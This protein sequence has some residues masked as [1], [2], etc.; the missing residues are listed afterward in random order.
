[1]SMRMTRR[2]LLRYAGLASSTGILAACQ[3]KVVEVT[4]IVEKVVEK[5]V[6]K[7]VKETVIVEGTPKV[8]EKVVKETVVVA[9][10]EPVTL[11]LVVMNYSWD[12]AQKTFAPEFTKQHPDIKTS[13]TV[14]PG[15]GDYPLKVAA[16]FASNTLGDVIEFNQGAKFYSW[17][18]TGMIRPLDDLVQATKFDINAF[19]PCG[20]KTSSFNGHL[21][22]LPQDTHPGM[23]VVHYNANLLQKLGVPEPT[24]AWDYNQFIDTCLKIIK[25]GSVGGRTD[26]WAYTHWHDL[27]NM[28]SRLRALGGDI[29]DQAGK[30]CL[31]DQ[32]AGIKALQL[33]QDLI[34]KH[35][36]HPTPGDLT[37]NDSD[38]LYRS[39]KLA[40]RGVTPTHVINITTATEKDFVT[41][42]CLMAKDPDNG[43]IGAA[44]TGM[45][46][47]ITTTCQHPQEAWEWLQFMGGKWYGTQ[48][49]FQGFGAPGGRKDTWGDPDVVKKWPLAKEVAA[50][51]ETAEPQR[52]PWNL[53]DAE[54]SSTSYAIVQDMLLN[55]MTGEEAG[56]RITAEIDKVL[57][58]PML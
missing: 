57:A 22:A 17:T 47:G 33:N 43:K 44:P 50:V 42:A 18:Q 29:Y 1:M 37:S 16:M 3:P 41:K 34:V 4:K 39:S 2:E 23:M 54:I 7:V 13:F 51:L 58:K 32:P 27:G 53:R 45:G 55:K 21:V 26:V 25:A 5:P 36:V 10:K 12:E 28:T 52:Y 35:K 31:L 11:N 56:K 38:V 15:F 49:F 6:E 30:K 14:V 20:I 19:Y 40:M 8:V 9:K 48:M 46:Y 24:S